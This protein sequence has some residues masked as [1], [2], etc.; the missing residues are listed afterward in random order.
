M[1]VGALP[2]RFGVSPWA[3]L[4]MAVDILL[5]VGRYGGKYVE[6][7]EHPF[8]AH[9]QRTHHEL[10]WLQVDLQSRLKVIRT[11]RLSIPNLTICLIHWQIALFNTTRLPYLPCRI[12]CWAPRRIMSLLVEKLSGFIGACHLLSEQMAQSLLFMTIITS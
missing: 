11:D 8:A 5:L 2:V 1:G 7:I 12:C 6:P 10:G 9:P 3:S 4:A